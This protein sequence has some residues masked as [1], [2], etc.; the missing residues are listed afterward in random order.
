ML[1]SLLTKW[2]K[3]K[4]PPKIIRKI[5]GFFNSERD[6]IE[7]TKKIFKYDYSNPIDFFSN[8]SHDAIWFFK[9]YGVFIES[10]IE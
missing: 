5:I 10:T 4:I 3:T 2:Y 1:I 8:F 7:W 9:N 6:V